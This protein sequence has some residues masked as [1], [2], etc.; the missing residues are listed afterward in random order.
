MEIKILEQTKT[1]AVFQIP[2]ADHTLCNALKKELVDVKG[3]TVATYAI[4]H[5]QVG[6]P[7]MLI[8]TTDKLTPKQAIKE[9]IK[10]LQSKNKE[11]LK[12]FKAAV[13]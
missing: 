3:V 2:G 11:F 8:E 7:K 4:E 9:G 13:K 6:I 12:K 10:L 5:P 1:R